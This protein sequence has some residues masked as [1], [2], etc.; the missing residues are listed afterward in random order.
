MF[1]QI[2]DNRSI[3]LNGFQVISVQILVP[4][5]SHRNHRVW[6]SF[7]LL[8]LFITWSLLIKNYFQALPCVH[9]IRNSFILV[10]NWTL[11]SLTPGTYSF[12]FLAPF[13]IKLKTEAHLSFSVAI[14]HQKKRRLSVNPG[15]FES[16]TACWTKSW[17]W[18][19]PDLPISSL[20]LSSPQISW[21]I[22]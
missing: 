20:A 2:P 3:P 14:N 12:A 10:W 1:P 15:I 11:N 13:L 8:N 6:F 22:V 17:T 5:A 19:M 4:R 21:A 18:H 16:R 7:L 9:A